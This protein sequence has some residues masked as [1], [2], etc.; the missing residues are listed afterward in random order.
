M[1]NLF[2]ERHGVRPYLKF[3]RCVFRLYCNKVDV[4]ISQFVNI[5]SFCIATTNLSDTFVVTHNHSFSARDCSP[6]S[7][8]S[9]FK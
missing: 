8:S 1:I 9:D 7:N 4:R 5:V 2:I 3:M 6:G